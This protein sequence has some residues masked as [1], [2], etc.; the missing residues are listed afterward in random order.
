M[1][2]RRR[3]HVARPQ[4]A[5][6]ELD[7]G[8]GWYVQNYRGSDPHNCSMDQFT[9]WFLILILIAVARVPMVVGSLPGWWMGENDGRKRGSVISEGRWETQLREQGFDGIQ[10]RFRDSEDHRLYPKPLMISVARL[11]PALGDHSY[12]GQTKEEE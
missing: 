12:S 5:L 1:T 4:P 7:P 11:A 3:V 6:A 10:L 8:G 9:L 2:A